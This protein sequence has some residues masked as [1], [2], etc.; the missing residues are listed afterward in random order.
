[1]SALPKHLGGH[2]H[3]TH[4]DVGVLNYAIDEFGVAS[5]LDLGCGPGGMV[6][7][8]KSL[9]LDVI[10]VDGDFTLIREDPAL[11]ITHD[12]TTGPYIPSKKYDMVWCNEF[13]EHVEKQYEVNW[14]TTMQ[15]A[16]YVFCTYSEPDTPGHH[17]VNCEPLSYW[18]SLFEKFG[19]AYL[20][21]ETNL[22]RLASTMERDFFRTKGL[23]FRNVSRSGT[24]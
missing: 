21:Q 16:K 3:R 17:H 18:V 2:K 23:V 12:Y 13:I 19:F 24:K 6:Y 4:V 1:M 7:A 10:G 22:A 20:E 14:I 9:G 11:F 8:A 5:M 15:S